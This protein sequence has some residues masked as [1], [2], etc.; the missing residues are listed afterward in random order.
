MSF[1]LKAG[2]MTALVPDAGSGQSPCAPGAAHTCTKA[3]E[4]KVGRDPLAERELVPQVGEG[5]HSPDLR[6]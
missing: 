2:H 6:R 1:A 5:A 3:A 4:G